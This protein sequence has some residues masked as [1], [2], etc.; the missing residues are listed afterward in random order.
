MSQPHPLSGHWQP[1]PHL[2]HLYYGPDCVSQHLLNALP[3][4][5]SKAI[6]I[7]GTTLATRTPL[8]QR[9]QTLL[10]THYVT[11][12]SSITQHTPSHTIDDAI[13]TILTLHAQDP[14]IDTLIS[15]GGGSPIDAAKILALRFFQA[16]TSTLTH[17]AIP[18]TLSAA[19]TTPAG[20]AT[21]P[22]GTK[23]G[24]RDAKMAVHAIFY[25]PAYTKY[26][27]MDLWLSTGIRALDHAVEAMYHP[28][29][30]EVP[31][32]ILAIYA[33]GELFECLPKAK[34]DCDMSD[35][36]TTVRLM[37]ASFASSGLKGEDLGNGMGLSHSLGY[38]LGTLGLLEQ[39]S[40]LIQGPQEFLH[41]FVA[42]HW[43]H[44]AL[45]AFLHS[46]TLEHIARSGRA[47]IEDLESQ[48]GIPA[49]KLARILGLLRCRRIIDEPEKGVYSLTAVSEELVK[50][51]DSR[52]CFEF[53]LF[54]TRIA[55][56]HLADALA[57]KPNGYAD[58]VSA[59]RE[60]FG[61]E[62]YDWHACHPDKGERFRRAMRGVSRA[63]DP[64]DSLI[65]GY[66]QQHTPTTKTKIVEIGGR[67]GFAAISLVQKHPELSFEVRSDS[68]E[69][70][71]R[72]DTH[73]PSSCRERI[74][75]TH[76]QSVFDS[77]PACD[78]HT[79]W[80]YVIRNLL[81]NWSDTD[82]VRLLRS[83]KQGAGA[84]TRVLITDGVSPV[85]GQ[86]P[87]HEEI[88]YRRRDVT[89]MSMHNVKQRTQ[90]EWVGVFK[91]ADPVV[92]VETMF[93]RSSH[94]YKGLWEIN[95]YRV[96]EDGTH[97][98][99]RLA[100]IESLL[101]P[102]SEGPVFHFHEMHDEGFYVTK[103]TVRFHSPGRADVDAKA[104]DFIIVPIRLP[105]RFSNPFDEEAVFMNTATP[106]F[107]VRYFEYLEYL[108]GEGTVLTPEINKAAL[109]RFA[110]VP[111]SKEDVS[112]LEME[113]MRNE[114]VTE[115]ET[116]G[117]RYVD[118]LVEER[119]GA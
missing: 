20:S 85:S 92:R 67:Y 107:F 68:Q 88:A 35:D 76:C 25:D 13:K 93:E 108:I 60:G 72:G 51:S 116:E 118:M 114:S 36:A 71:D 110:T 63:L 19:E 24:I 112:R 96:M 75:F 48:S 94:V 54:E 21:Q 81:W 32:K 12:I 106:G 86:F 45:Y 83:I 65:E 98:Q 22:D 69:F 66:I 62:M 37:L 8:V 15:L 84:S 52:A 59:F 115:S 111:V 41:D 103:G 7:T 14:T 82:V 4:P 77:P 43:D 95:L 18:T 79:V 34:E 87:L 78:E 30:S 80:L 6:I 70:L 100:A 89:T 64:A 3:S 1:N 46:Q 17:L 90:E 74:A 2:Q 61:M 5:T 11:T 28:T 119:K 117:E 31:W 97:T 105:H 102:H 50:D 27:P 91:Q 40:I 47:S 44:G 9:L 55:S 16:T 53:Q 42:S 49:D 39:L 99:Y 10:A 113:G 26:T 73:V 109:R 58:G 57:R 56:A 33:V 29:A 23:T 38:A 101:P 104:G